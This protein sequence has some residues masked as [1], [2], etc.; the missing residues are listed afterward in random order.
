MPWTSAGIKEVPVFYLGKVFRSST[1]AGDVFLDYKFK[2][3]VKSEFNFRKEF[4]NIVVYIGGLSTRR[5]DFILLKYLA[6]NLPKTAFVL[7]AKTDGEN[8]TEHELSKLLR[9]NNVYH[10]GNL[11]YYDLPDLVHSADAGIV[12]YLVN[13]DTMGICPNKIFEYASLGKPVLSTPVPAVLDY[14]PPIQICHNKDIFLA[15]LKKLISDQPDK[16]L[17]KQMKL[18]ARKTS[19]SETLKRMGKLIYSN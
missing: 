18:L 13:E 6:S 9:L 5:I 16:E 12:P 10:F 4:S 3:S 17:K 7:G 19:P 8:K 2:T 14:S 15:N 11:N 1:C